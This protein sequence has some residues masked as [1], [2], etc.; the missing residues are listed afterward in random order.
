[1]ILIDVAGVA[2]AV[3]VDTAVAAA[4]VAAKVN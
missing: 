3:I 2:V 4:V 1:M